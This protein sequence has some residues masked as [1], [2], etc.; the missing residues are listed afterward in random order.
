MAN[1]TLDQTGQEIQ[2]IL[3]TVGNN[4]ATQGQ[5]LTADG[6]GGASWQ[7]A[8]G[9][10][11]YA[12]YTMLDNFTKTFIFITNSSTTFTNDSLA[13]YLYNNGFNDSSYGIKN[14]YVTIDSS[15]GK[16]TRNTSLYATSTSGTNIMMQR[17]VYTPQID[18]QTFTLKYSFASS[19]QPVTIS[20]EIVV[21]I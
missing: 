8:S 21:Q 10:S 9:G 1:F 7:N 19:S 3:D 16:I 15:T 11:L 2:D 18:S 6:S 17:L 5:V 20:R 12:H 14:T 13:T 4:Q